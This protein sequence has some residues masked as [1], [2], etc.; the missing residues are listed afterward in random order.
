MQ[1]LALKEIDG[2]LK[3]MLTA[4]PVWGGLWANTFGTNRNIT[5]HINPIYLAGQADRFSWVS[6]EETQSEYDW[7]KLYNFLKRARDNGYYYY[8]HE[9]WTGYHALE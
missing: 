9:L 5:E 2:V 8:Y 4:R 6:I 7:S 1:K 3:E